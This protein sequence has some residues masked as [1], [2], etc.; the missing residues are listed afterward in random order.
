MSGGS[1]KETYDRAVFGMWLYILSDFLFFG[2]LFAVYAFFKDYALA[3]QIYQLG[4]AFY[5]T[6]ALLLS[7]TSA[8]IA[9]A[10]LHR[11]DRKKTLIFFFLAF[12]LGLFFS[13]VEWSHWSDLLGKGY[14]WQS[15]AF[16]SAY[17]TLIGTH[18]LHLLFCLFWMVVLIFPLFF[19][20][21]SARDVRRLTCWRM[22]WQFLNIVWIFIFTVVYLMGVEGMYG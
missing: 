20:E 12:L 11:R 21:I 15:S 19:Q 5:A 3:D 7:S 17:F 6:L 18:Q 2:T 13:F 9:G 22:F 4:K 1:C 8:G 16:L 10:Y 14:T